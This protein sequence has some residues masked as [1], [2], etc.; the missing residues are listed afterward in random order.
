M[1]IFKLL[2]LAVLLILPAL[3]YA[4]ALDGVEVLFMNIPI[5]IVYLLTG[6][7]GI[8]FFSLLYYRHRKYRRYAFWFIIPSLV[9]SLYCFGV[10]KLSAVESEDRIATK[11]LTPAYINFVVFAII[12]GISPWIKHNPIIENNK[13]N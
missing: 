9:F 5:M 7:A 1:K 6:L 10:G 8:S 3:T 12:I 4:D 11:M 13:N 2:F